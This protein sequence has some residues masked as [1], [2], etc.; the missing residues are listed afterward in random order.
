[1]RC[2]RDSSA[3]VPLPR[4]SRQAPEEP[5]AL[6]RGVPGPSWVAGWPPAAVSEVRAAVARALG[7][8]LMEAPALTLPRRRRCRAA[9]DRRPRSA[10]APWEAASALAAHSQ[11][12]ARVAPG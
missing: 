3:P 2:R 1:M 10:E 4:H 9:A 7:Q 11:L 12:R 6:A 8:A 5:P